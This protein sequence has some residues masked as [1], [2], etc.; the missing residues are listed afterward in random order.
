MSELFSILQLSQ[1]C[2]IPPVTLRAWERRYGLLKPQRTASGHR[3]YSEADVQR[4]QQIV[5]WLD[6]GVPVGQVRPLLADTA[7]PPAAADEPRW[8]E[9]RL[10]M[11]AALDSLSP[12]RLEQQ[13]NTLLADY[14]HSRVFN[15]VL[16]PLR[17]QL[18]GSRALAAQAA[19]L[20][21]VLLAKWSARL[22]SLAPNKRQ[23]GWLLLPVGEPL[24]ALELAMVLPG[25]LWA[26]F[27]APSWASLHPLLEQRPLAGVL[28]VLDRPPSAREQRALWPDDP[29][30]Q[31]LLCWN[32]T[33]VP[34]P[35]S[36]R[37]IHGHRDQV[38]AQLAALSGEASS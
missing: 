11:L 21:S 38:A 22:L 31:R 26:L 15:D 24:A 4:V 7:A 35:A 20:D 17:A 5:Q 1:R 13:L 37:E 23:P 14:G 19:L 28:W 6:K 8:Q 36:L 12:R 29:G 25:P 9:A 10:Q 16:D 34:L 2:G 27:Q 32:Q 18:C 3:R 30:E 33:G